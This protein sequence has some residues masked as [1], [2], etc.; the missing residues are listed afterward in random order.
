MDMYVCLEHGRLRYLRLNQTKIRAELYTGVLEAMDNEQEEITGRPVILPSSFIGGTRSM[1]QLYQDAMALVTRFGKPSYFLTMT[2]NPNWP[3]IQNELEYG[4]TASDR[5]DLVARVFHLKFHEMLDDVTK[6]GRLGTCVSW[7]YTIEFQKRGLPHGHL[8]LI[9]DAASSPRTP[10]DIDLIVSAQIPCRDTE[11][12]LYDAVSQFMLHGP[13]NTSRK[14]WDGSKCRLGFP[15]SFEEHT[16]LGDDSYPTYG[17]PDNGRS[18]RKGNHIYTNGDVVPHNLYL[19]LKYRC[20]LNVEVAISI[21][22]V[23]YLFK[24]ITKGHDRTSLSIEE[25][26]EKDEILQYLNGRYVSAPE[27]MQYS[28]FSALNDIYQDIGTNEKHGIIQPSGVFL[29]LS[30]LGVFQQSHA[31]VFTLKQITR[32]T[33]RMMQHCVRRLNQVQLKEQ[34]SQSSSAYARKMHR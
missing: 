16:K 32:S 34:H 23:K 17:R 33:L 5:P 10:A 28:L 13:C 29:N 2:A 3:E 11:P 22:A 6:H 27:G 12:Q 14:C 25:E 31:S 9:M 19:L 30:Y 1:Q 8:I 4:Q 7:V 15:R 18:I 26:N 24:Y 21:A 20:H